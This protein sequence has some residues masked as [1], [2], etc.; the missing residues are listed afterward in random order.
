MRV[1]SI[2]SSALLMAMSSPSFAHISH[3]SESLHHAE[4]S[5][6]ALSLLLPVVLYGAWKVH[7]ALKAKRAE[8]RSP[9]QQ[10]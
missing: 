1:I 6:I 7:K 9:R 2:A 3:A 5:L 8:C 10:R 4:H